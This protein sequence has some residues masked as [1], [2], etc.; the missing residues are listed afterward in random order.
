[1]TW[2][3]EGMLA[4]RVVDGRFFRLFVFSLF[5]LFALFAIDVRIF[6][7]IADS[8]KVAPFCFLEQKWGRTDETQQKVDAF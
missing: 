4:T 6:V 8:C 3:F 1:M 7:S 2:N 5:L